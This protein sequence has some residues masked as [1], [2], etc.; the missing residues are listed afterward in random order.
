M[1]QHFD[2]SLKL[3]FQR[4]MGVVARTLFGGPV[5]EWLNVELPRVQNP[6][7]DLLARGSD[8]TYRHLELESRNT[9]QLGL[10]VA[11]YHLGLFRRLGVSVEMVVL[12]V[13]K[14]PLR[15]ADEFATPS[16][17]FH[18]RLLDIRQFDGEPLAASSDLGDNMLALLTGCDRERVMRRVEDR[19]R[20]LPGGEKE[21]A[22]R[23]FVV[24]SGL[25]SLETTV[26]RR[27]NMIDIMENK[28]LGPAVLRG[29]HQ[30]Q[31]KF[32]SMQ[33]KERFGGKL[34][35]WVPTKLEEASERQ[36]ISWGKRVLTAK[37]LEAVFKR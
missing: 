22:A 10:R 5:A 28:V 33:L 17:R 20:M 36:L 8:G 24:I 7:A 15:M 18:F 11:E 21:E 16:M 29:E 13:G 32:L 14:R 9:R 37:T 12:Y 23:L 35:D 25:R 30:G 1:A 2:V 31:A 34:P 27:L 6:R 19:I 4:S 3:L 26:A